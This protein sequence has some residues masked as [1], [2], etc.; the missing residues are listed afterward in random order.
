MALRNKSINQFLYFFIFFLLCISMI[1]TDLPIYKKTVTHSLVIF[2]AP[3]I[4][5]FILITK[6]FKI[7]LTKNL[8]LSALYITISFL[9]S[10]ILLS[11][12][13]LKRGEI[14]V[15]NYNIF[16]KHFEAFVSLSLLHFIVYYLLIMAL[17]SLSLNLIKKIIFLFFSFLT[18]AG[19][20]EYLFPE[21]LEIFHSGPKNYE[22]L[23]L[24]T[25]EPSQA[26][27]L[28][29]IFSL[30][31]LFFAERTIFYILI[32]TFSG[33][34][35]T[36]IGSKGGFISLLSTAILLFFKRGRHLKYIMVMVLILPIIFYIF[37]SLILPAILIDIEKFTSFSTRFSSLIAIAIILAKYPLGLGYGSYL[38]Y[39]PEILDQGYE[40]ANNL[41]IKLT[42]I[43]LSYLEISDI[44][45]TGQ[46]IGTKAGI[47]QSIMFNGWIALLFWLIILRN[48]LKYIK[49]LKIHTSKKF[50]LEFLI[51][52][53]FI[54]L[55]IGSEYTLL[56]AI[57]LPI[58]FIEV[59]CYKQQEA[60]IQ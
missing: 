38:F 32:L 45:S 15:Y 31:A 25:S 33:L 4:F 21:V 10:L 52:Y 37:T 14:Y 58:A 22:R 47:P 23:R 1:F 34:L 40:I 19:F 28:Y 57:W 12:L 36:L 30:I 9:V 54:Q 29:T 50:I 17:N 42:G 20:I 56:Y 59:M 24:F 2:F 41:L 7:P 16:I 11:F 35:F 26:V 44:I 46:N 27:L 3:L 51:L 39:F 18:L 60:Y 5:V 13:I 55:F 8:K 43:Q 49:K 48:S 53:I 6:K